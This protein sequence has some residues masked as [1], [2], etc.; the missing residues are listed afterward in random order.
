MNANQTWTQSNRLAGL[1]RFAIAITLLNILG[2]TVFGFEQSWAQPLVS[3]AAA[4]TME[5][6]L[7][8]AGGKNRRPRAWLSKDTIDFL[9]PAHI[10]GLAVAMLLY[11]NDRLWPIAFASAAA[12]GSKAIFRVGAGSRTRHFF[13][14]SNFG[15]SVTLLLFPWVGIAP[16]YHFTE[17]LVGVGSWILPGVIVVSGTFLNVRFTHKLPLIGTWLGGFALQA[18]IRSWW[19]GTPPAAA[20]LPMT[21]VAFLLYTF[22]MVTDPATSPASARGQIVFGAAV[23]CAYSVLMI[24]HVVFGLFFALTIVCALRGVILYWQARQAPP[25]RVQPARKRTEVELEPVAAGSLQP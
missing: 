6:I 21:G 17:N 18:L 25:E 3:L 16:P 9:L 2:H 13:N 8:L 1:R 20:W 4:Y 7:E 12:I 15:I 22:Y 14:P 11:A 10:T 24:A 23:A 5:I 19:F